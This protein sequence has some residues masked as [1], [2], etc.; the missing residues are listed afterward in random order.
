MSHSETNSFNTFSA[1]RSF[2]THSIFFFLHRLRARLGRQTFECA[3]FHTNKT[4]LPSECFGRC[5]K[6][7]VCVIARIYWN[8]LSLSRSP[9]V[10]AINTFRSEFMCACTTHLCLNESNNIWHGIPMGDMLYTPN[11]VFIV[12]CCDYLHA[13]YPCSPLQFLVLFA[14]KMR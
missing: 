6:K 5:T 11:I 1:R 13:F 3:C 2:R 9:I 8:R 4:I 10:L 12:S 7:E 14:A